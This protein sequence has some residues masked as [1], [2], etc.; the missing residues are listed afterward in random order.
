MNRAEKRR[1]QRSLSKERTYTYTESQ[2]RVVIATEIARYERNTMN[3]IKKWEEDASRS[4]QKLEE[5]FYHQAT[6]ML[7]VSSMHALKAEFKFGQG[8]LI[9]YIDA[10]TDIYDLISSQDNF[11]EYEEIIK[12]MGIE[13]NFIGKSEVGK[14]E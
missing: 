3:K 14:N 8:R 7:L 9:R 12:D 2:L 13:I 5:S 4:L 1:Q 11:S 10:I 6:K